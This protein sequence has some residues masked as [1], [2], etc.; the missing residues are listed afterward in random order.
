ME[1]PMRAWQTRKN[2]RELL[3]IEETDAWFEYLWATR[4]APASCYENIE[5]WAWSRLSGRLRA[6]RAR[7]AELVPV[8]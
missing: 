8:A 4:E 3:E 6:I 2:V 1:A 5:Y 7:Q